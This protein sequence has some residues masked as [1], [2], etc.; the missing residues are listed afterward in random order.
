MSTRPIAPLKRPN[1]ANLWFRMI[2]AFDLRAA[3]GKREIRE[4]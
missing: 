4:S 2:V 3:I 1:S